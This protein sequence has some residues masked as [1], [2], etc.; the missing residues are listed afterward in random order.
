[1]CKSKESLGN[2]GENF[3]KFSENINKIVKK[4]LRHLE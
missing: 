1:M 4:I 3:K 2:Y